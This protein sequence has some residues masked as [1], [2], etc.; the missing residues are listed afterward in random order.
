M[1]SIF[2][3]IVNNTSILKGLVPASVLIVALLVCFA[4]LVY[5]PTTTIVV[6]NDTNSTIQ[7]SV[8]GSNPATIAPHQIVDVD[9]SSN[10]TK[11]AC[12]VYNMQDHYIGCLPIPTT[13]KQTLFNVSK[14]NKAIPLK[15]CGD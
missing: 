3:R 7:E 12:V 4:W 15:K 5:T 9:A 2:Y 14:L 13:G 11:E 8:C 1:R 6:R 10:D